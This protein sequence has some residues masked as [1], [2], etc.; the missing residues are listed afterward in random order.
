MNVSMRLNDPNQNHLLGVVFPPMNSE[1]PSMP[2]L[3]TPA[4]SDE[5]PFSST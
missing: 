2:S 5:L 3:P 1:I 4:I